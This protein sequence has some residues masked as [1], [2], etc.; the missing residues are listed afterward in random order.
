MAN[1]ELTVIRA[2]G[3]IKTLRSSDVKGAGVHAQLVGVFEA[4]EEVV[5]IA[6]GSVRYNVDSSPGATLD[7]PSAAAM[8]GRLRVYETTTPSTPTKRLYYRQD[9]TMPNA[10]GAD[11]QGYL[12]HGEVMI[13]RLADFTQ[14]KMIADNTDNGVFEVY[15]E[16]LNLPSS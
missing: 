14:F 11:A 12:L 1:N 15:V 8:F 9:G 6:G 10:N 3:Q 16:W 13:V 2:D 5:A 7:P 4:P